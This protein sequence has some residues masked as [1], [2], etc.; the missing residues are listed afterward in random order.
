MRK[1][2]WKSERKSEKEDLPKNNKPGK[3]SEVG[4]RRRMM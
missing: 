3:L 4:K 2:E 1:K